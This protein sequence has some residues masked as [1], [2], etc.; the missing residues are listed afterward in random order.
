[1]VVGLLLVLIIGPKKWRVFSQSP[2][3]YTQTASVTYQFNV[4]KHPTGLVASSGYLFIA[5]TGNNLVRQFANGSLSVLAGN[6]QAGYVDG[7]A[8]SAEFNKPT[9]L[10]GGMGTY[11]FCVQGCNC[12][13]VYCW[14]SGQ[15][16]RLYVND[17]QNYVVREICTGPPSYCSSQV[18]TV[19]GNHVQG[20]LDGSS[21][22][23]EFGNTAGIFG[24]QSSPSPSA[25]LYIADGQNNVVRSWD[26]S[27]VATYAG[28]GT[29]GYVNAYRTS[30][31]FGTPVKADWDS[32]GNMYVT[33]TDNFVI[34]KID[35]AGNVTTFAGT[36]HNGF[37]NGAGSQ[38]SFR[39]PTGVAFNSA[40]GYLYVA[41]T[42]NNVIRRIDSAGNVSTY[43]GTGVAGLTNGSLSQ[44]QFFAPT[45][46]VIV[47]GFMFVSDSN[48]NVIREID[49][50]NQV[51]SIY[52]S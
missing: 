4:L 5:D 20:Y 23:A 30:A 37:V 43:A 17:T 35:T 26:G 34:R 29:R 13:P 44:A 15:Y 3:D 22:S 21:L 42:Q 14:V 46:L 18:S 31:Q 9:G 8:S 33:D 48:N 25:P 11:R 32:N 41:D 10:V 19:A 12:Q 36:G 27:N 24:K 45:D 1:L 7:Q 51:V 52:I 6:G 28:N 50:T 39:Y 40:D 16:A 2:T 49:M 38:A 47:N